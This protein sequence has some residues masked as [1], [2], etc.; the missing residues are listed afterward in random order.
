LLSLILFLFLLLFFYLSHHSFC[1]LNTFADN[2][3][4]EGKKEYN[5]KLLDMLLSSPMFREELFMA[6][7]ESAIPEALLICLSSNFRDIFSREL[8]KRASLEWKKWPLIK[9][10]Q[11]ALEPQDAEEIF[12]KILSLKRSLLLL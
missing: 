10:I 3:S 6:F 8:F 7:S 1:I 11:E 12:V 4:A 9:E 5:D 2:L